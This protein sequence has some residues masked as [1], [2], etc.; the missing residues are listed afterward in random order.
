MREDEGKGSCADGE[1]I[2]RGNDAECKPL[3]G[4]NLIER[5]GGG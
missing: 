5:G 1:E 4:R 3:W 2:F